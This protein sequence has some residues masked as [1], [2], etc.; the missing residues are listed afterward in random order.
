MLLALAKGKLNL[1][2]L[3]EVAR[4]TTEISAMVF[5]ILIG[6]SLFSLVFRGFGGEVLIEDVFQQLPGGVLGVPFFCLA[7]N[8]LTAATP[9]S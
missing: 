6:A 9:K 2:Q 4:G 8:R 7:P 3:R 5:L 1:G